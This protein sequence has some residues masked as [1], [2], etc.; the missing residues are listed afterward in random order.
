MFIFT[1]QKKKERKKDI[2]AMFNRK[3]NF[4]RSFYLSIS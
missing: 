2:Y 3:D 4:F 1:A